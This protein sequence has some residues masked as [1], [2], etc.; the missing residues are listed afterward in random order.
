MLASSLR[1]PG[2][3]LI[4]IGVL[5]SRRVGEELLLHAAPKDSHV[6]VGIRVS[7]AKAPGQHSDEMRLEVHRYHVSHFA[8]SLSFANVSRKLAAM[9]CE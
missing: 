2:C 9:H 4:A 8:S 3:P 1:S 5:P 7:S 6:H